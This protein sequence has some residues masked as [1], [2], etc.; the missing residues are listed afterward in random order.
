MLAGR[1]GHWYERTKR[2]DGSRHTCP[3]STCK[4]SQIK[5]TR[6]PMAQL[7]ERSQF[8]IQAEGENLLHTPEKKH[9]A[10][11]AKEFLRS[12]LNDTN[13]RIALMGASAFTGIASYILANASVYKDPTGIGVGALMIGFAVGAEAMRMRAYHSR[14][15]S[16]SRQEGVTDQS[17]PLSEEYIAS[18][19][20][21]MPTASY[22][23]SSEQT[24]YREY[25]EG[26]R[27]NE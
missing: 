12:F 27:G 23:H 22:P 10:K 15:A 16:Q 8:Q 25:N 3:C 4:F 7:P 9:P 5:Y 24:R 1:N 6:Y 11:A 2:K 26:Y 17:Y 18:A 21:T 13:E 19:H 14:L 20:G